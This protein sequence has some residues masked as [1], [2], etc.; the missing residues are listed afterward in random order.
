MS[1][2]L[3]S[4]STCILLF[5]AL[6]SP[7]VYAYTP[8]QVFTRASPSVVVVDV[9]D[10][11]GKQISLASGVVI[12]T[13]HVITNCHVLQKGKNI[14]IRQSGNTFKA[15]L[16]FA[17]YPRDLCQ[18]SVPTLQ[19]P[20]VTIGAAKNL[21]VGQRVYA[22]G[23][24][25]GLE[26]TLSEGLI[27]SLRN[28]EGSQYIQT[29]TALSP[30]SS[31]GGLFDDQGQ[32]IGI[33]TF[34]FTEGQNLNFALPVNWIAELPKRVQASS[35]A[36]KEGGVDWF[37]RVIAL[38]R[39]RDWQGLLELAQLWVKSDPES[40]D[41][42]FCLGE[43]YEG[44]EQYDEAV[45]SYR[46]ALRI[47]PK[48]AASWYNLGTTYDYLKQYNEAMRAY[49]EALRIQPKDA[50]AWFR[51]GM[52]YGSGLNQYSDAIKAF[53]E[54]LR[55][56]PTDVKSWYNLG[57]AYYENK[58]YDQ[59]IHAL[60]EAL[61]L[62]PEFYEAWNNLGTAYDRLMQYDEAIQSYREALRIQPKDVQSLYN[63]GLTY[64]K[65][66]QYDQALQAYRELLSIEPKNVDAWYGL[67]TT[68]FLQSPQGANK[69]LVQDVYNT[70]LKLN[71]TI[72]DKYFRQFLS[73]D[74]FVHAPA[75]N[76]KE[77]IGPKRSMERLSNEPDWSNDDTTYMGSRFIAFK[78]PPSTWSSEGGYGLRWGMGPGDVN[79][80]YPDLQFVLGRGKHIQGGFI[81]QNI[82]GSNVTVFFYFLHGRLYEV[83]IGNLK[84]QGSERWKW[85]ERM[86]SILEDGYG[87]PVCSPTLK[88]RINEC[89]INERSSCG[90]DDVSLSRREKLL[91]WIWRTSETEVKISGHSDKITYSDLLLASSV[92]QAEEANALALKI[93]RQERQ[94][95]ERQKIS[96][97]IAN[98]S[99]SA[100]SSFKIDVLNFDL[101]PPALECFKDSEPSED[102]STSKSSWSKVG[103]GDIK[104]GMGP[105]DV[106]AHVGP[107]SEFNWSVGSSRWVNDT[108][109]IS[110]GLKL[111]GK[112]VEGK[113]QFNKGRLTSLSLDLNCP[114]SELST[115][116]NRW[117]QSVLAD[118]DKKYGRARCVTINK[119]EKCHWDLADTIWADFTRYKDTG[120]A[121]LNFGDPA[122]HPKRISILG[123]VGSTSKK[124]WAT[125]GWNEFRWGMGVSDVRR[126][127]FD[128]KG[129]FKSDADLA[130]YTSD[131]SLEIDCTIE[132][133][134]HKFQVLGFVPNIK[135]NFL[136]RHLK[137]ITLVFKN[138]PEGDVHW[139][140]S[141]KL[142][143]LLLEKYGKPDH[144]STDSP[145][146]IY[147]VW[148]SKES[149]ISLD[150]TNLEDD[151]YISVT[152]T[153]PLTGS[154]DV[155]SQRG[156]DRKL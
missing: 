29:S 98:T 66:K 73:P 130:C 125:G 63:L 31:G 153:N 9:I 118:F 117:H 45:R 88:T 48:D 105:G 96:G 92:I 119:A 41:A 69:M 18:L 128:S 64:S 102:T 86:R 82:Q 49:Q 19:A 70:L 78:T 95:I 51:L 154:K 16:Q 8:E 26:L 129:D 24:P 59:S 68:Y 97:K 101:P 146:S 30:G 80:V 109:M 21:A 10:A 93:N 108:L 94:D 77:N 85:K 113:F 36:K 33:T 143:D 2:R 112:M 22:I 99:D 114:D 132:S 106:K 4:A 56:Q 12:G 27:S 151:S 144:E 1:L 60:Q 54:A 75:A 20:S 39:N 62:N 152:Y 126:K 147:L 44:T 156:I 57:L 137:S 74:R 52:T 65:R 11:E 115:S 79:A 58:Q 104:W 23:A 127:L 148:E 67:G 38:E 133:S 71:S 55:I 111:N 141:E 50:M 32:L 131:Q 90:S 134:F 142:R 5:M 138:F 28:Y 83:S 3:A 53:S 17:D 140:T 122:G 139:R 107:Q 100:S 61:R 76:S 150:S 123:D 37:S 72:A 89:D 43:G 40:A 7:C 81:V 34:Q 135:F 14:Q 35:V 149:K 124:S 6:A 121:G 145:K 103:F 155:R 87:S 110:P 15:T 136:E 91:R 116:C 13:G 46:E 120:V 42:W 25:Q 84:A 47:Q